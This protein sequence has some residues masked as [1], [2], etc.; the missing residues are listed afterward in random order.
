MTKHFCCIIIIFLFSLKCM[1]INTADKYYFILFL[2]FPNPLAL[3]SSLLFLFAQT[4]HS[5]SVRNTVRRQTQKSQWESQMNSYAPSQSNGMRR[6]GSDPALNKAGRTIAQQYKRSYTVRCNRATGQSM[7]RQENN[8]LAS[9]SQSQVASIVPS[10]SRSQ[11]LTQVTM[12][13]N[14]SEALG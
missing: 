2:I 3:Y 9:S 11:T 6:G 12:T 13:K 7:R 8:L 14:K 4:S 5:L 10:L 1:H